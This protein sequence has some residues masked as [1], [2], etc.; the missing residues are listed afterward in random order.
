MKQ[1]IILLIGAI[2]SMLY[3]PQME[4]TEKAEKV[5]KKLKKALGDQRVD[6][7]ELVVLDRKLIAQ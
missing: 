6:W 1:L 4:N 3:T 7:P 2:G 5:Y